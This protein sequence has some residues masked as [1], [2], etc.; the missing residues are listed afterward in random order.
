MSGHMSLAD[1][2]LFCYAVMKIDL[3]IH[4]SHFYFTPFPFFS[5][6]YTALVPH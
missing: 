4:A 1:M 6:I 2:F 3:P 5:S